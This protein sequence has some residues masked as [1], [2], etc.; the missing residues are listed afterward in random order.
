MIPSEAAER[1]HHDIAGSKLIIFDDLGH[2]PHEEDPTRTVVP[3]KQ[4][5]EAPSP[6]L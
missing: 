3:V 1:F 6:A 4:F 2:V 5:L